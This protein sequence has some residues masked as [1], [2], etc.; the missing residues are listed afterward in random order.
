MEKLKITQAV[1]VE[2][3]YDKIKLS[4]VLD[5]NIICTN[6]F[7]IYKDKNAVELIKHYAKTCGII[8][9]TD[10]DSAGHQIRNHLKSMIPDGNIINLYI[11]EIFGK[12]KRKNTPSKEGML[13][14]EGISIEMLRSIFERS[15]VLLQD[16]PDQ[17]TVTRNDFYQLGLSGKPNSSELRK[18][19]CKKL[20]LPCSLSAKALVGYV[21]TVCDK[22]TLSDLVGQI[23]AEQS[24]K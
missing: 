7:G 14:V 13:G 11:P 10:S 20:N 16:K 24:C 23:I 3:K 9:L 17:E 4:A 22:K 15:G 12:E 6:G 8:I 5:A 19:L 1:I 18:N 2:G 21:N